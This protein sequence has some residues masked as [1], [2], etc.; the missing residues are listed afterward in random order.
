M[1]VWRS[2]WCCVYTLSTPLRP[3]TI[4]CA[5]ERRFFSPAESVGAGA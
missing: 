5:R 4:F 3:P 2:G 1:V